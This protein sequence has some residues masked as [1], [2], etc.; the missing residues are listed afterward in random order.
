MSKAMS[1]AMARI[2]AR[3]IHRGTKAIEDV[4]EE[5]QALV[6]EQYILLFGVEPTE[7][8]TEEPSK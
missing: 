7:E 4:P 3:C 2:I 5:H 8:A 1:K 6:R